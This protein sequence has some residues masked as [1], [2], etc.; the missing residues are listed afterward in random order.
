VARV[1]HVEA[2]VRLVRDQVLHAAA[3]QTEV[4][5]ALDDPANRRVVD[6]GQGAA[7]PARLEPGLLRRQHHLVDRAAGAREAAADGVGASDVRGVALEL[8][9]RVD[10]DQLVVAQLLVVGDVVE[11]RG[12]ATAAD[13]GRV[14]G[15]ARAAAAKG[16][17]DHRLEL[18]LV[19]GPAREPGGGFVALARD[20]RRAPHHVE[21]GG[22]LE[23]AHLVDDPARIDD[24]LGGLVALAGAQ[25]QALERLGD[26]RVHGRIASEDVVE[27]L[28]PAHEIREVLG[29]RVIGVR[30]VGLVVASRAVDPGPVPGPGLRAA[31]SRLDVEAVLGSTVGAQHGD[32]VGM[33]ES[34][35]VREVAVLSKRVVGVARAGDQR[36]AQQD[37]DGSGPHGVTDLLAALGEHPTILAQGR[38]RQTTVTS[39]QCVAQTRPSLSAAV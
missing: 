29:E 23:Q 15:A 16:V 36:R 2:P 12:I 28:R 38:S 3:Q 5:E 33:V 39:P 26:L 34:R 20:V 7:R 35:Q 31:V 4:D 18:V 24:R 17:L 32:G 27:P 21:L 22:L 9:A 37:R 30:L 25:P 1:V 10:Q 14:G 6:R 13:D 19:D 11:D 8:A